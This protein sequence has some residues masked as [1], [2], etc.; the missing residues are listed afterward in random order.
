[1]CDRCKD[2]NKID[3][4]TYTIHK[5]DASRATTLCDECA[6]I[7]HNAGFKLT[8]GK[9]I[10]APEVETPSAPEPEEAEE[11]EAEEASEPRPT[12]YEPPARP[13]RRRG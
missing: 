4:S 11:T 3:V 6:A 13:S 1:M 10:K 5:G 12:Q 2:A 8:G 7:T 9:A